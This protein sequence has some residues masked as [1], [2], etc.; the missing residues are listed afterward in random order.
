MAPQ[1]FARKLRLD[2]NSQVFDIRERV[3]APGCPTRPRRRERP[4]TGR[5]LRGGRGGPTHSPG[6]WTQV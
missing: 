6:D 1:V 2:P 3:L 5:R 4:A